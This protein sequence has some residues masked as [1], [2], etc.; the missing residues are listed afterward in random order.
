MT[1]PYKRG[2]RLFIYDEDNAI[3][4]YIGKM[5]EK[6]KQMNKEW[7][8]KSGRQLFN[9][10]ENGEYIILDSVGLGREN[11]KDKESRDDYLD[12]WNYELNMETEYMMEELRKEFAL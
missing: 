1:K 9:T 6:D 5:T 4:Y 11:W 2:E 12:Q 7:L 10:V 8:E 3:V